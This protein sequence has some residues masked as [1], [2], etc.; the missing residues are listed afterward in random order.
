MPAAAVCL[1]P[2]PCIVLAL[3]W[4]QMWLPLRPFPTPP[5]GTALRWRHVV[6]EL[7][8]LGVRNHATL[9]FVM[10]SCYAD[11]LKAP[12]PPP[13]IDVFRVARA[14]GGPARG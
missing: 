4:C 14:D 10:A 2:G 13:C 11:C 12:P 9:L 6:D 3:L 1:P 8:C 7:L 5:H